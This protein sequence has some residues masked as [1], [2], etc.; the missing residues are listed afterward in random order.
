MKAINCSDQWITGLKEIKISN[1]LIIDI[2][3]KT[4]I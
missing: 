3:I 1:L 2:L 4:I